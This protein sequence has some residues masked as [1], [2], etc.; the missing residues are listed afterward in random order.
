MSVASFN[1]LLQSFLSLFQYF[2]AH[3]LSC[4]LASQLFLKS[5]DHVLKNIKCH[6]KVILC[7]AMF[8]VYITAGRDQISIRL[9]ELAILC[10]EHDCADDRGGERDEDRT[11]HTCCQSPVIAYP[12]PSAN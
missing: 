7:R 9:R 5:E 11:R 8:G 1:E 6:A 3:L 4:W 10:T 12:A 2:F